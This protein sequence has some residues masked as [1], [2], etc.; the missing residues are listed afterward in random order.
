MKFAL[1][2]LIV[3]GSTA[4]DNSRH[5]VPPSTSSKPQA[6]VTERHADAMGGGVFRYRMNVKVGDDSFLLTC[7]E[8]ENNLAKRD[9]N[10]GVND[11]VYSLDWDVRDCERKAPD[12]APAKSGNPKCV[13]SGGTVWEVTKQ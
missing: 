6:T 4:C 1:L 2:L 11:E 13:N 7:T 10:W 9:C 3:V 5:S 8:D 12:P